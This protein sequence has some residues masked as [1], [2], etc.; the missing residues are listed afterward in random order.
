MNKENIIFQPNNIEYRF[1]VSLL[2]GGK[3]DPTEEMQIIFP[4]NFV[5]AIPR[6]GEIYATNNDDGTVSSNYRIREV[7]HNVGVDR[8]DE[9]LLRDLVLIEAVWVRDLPLGIAS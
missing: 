4:L 9:T 5:P 3:D 2:E 7:L 6:I 8:I 1:I